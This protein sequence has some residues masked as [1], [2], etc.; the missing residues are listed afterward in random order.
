MVRRPAGAGHSAST[1]GSRLRTASSKP[2]RLSW[3]VSALAMDMSASMERIFGSRSA[4]TS[5]ALAMDI[6]SWVSMPK[7]HQVM[8]RRQPV[9]E[10]A[11]S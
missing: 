3:I 10:K 9:Q 5:S 2:A 8:Q 11:A 4:P 1:S 6:T 7:G